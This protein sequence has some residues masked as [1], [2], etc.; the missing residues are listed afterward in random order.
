MVL[1]VSGEKSAQIKLCLRAK[2]ALNKC[3]DG[4][5]A[6]QQEMNFLHWRKRNKDYGLISDG[7]KLDMS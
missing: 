4:F 2:T 6:R 3:V 7:L 5:D 1:S